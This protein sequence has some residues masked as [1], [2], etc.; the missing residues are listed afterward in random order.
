MYK[1]KNVNFFL[2]YHKYNITL[3]MTTKVKKLWSMC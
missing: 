2:E 1:Y 3:K